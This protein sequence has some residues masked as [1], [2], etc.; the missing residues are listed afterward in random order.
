M[1]SERKEKEGAEC[2][3]F[4]GSLQEIS[5]VYT[6]DTQNIKVLSNLK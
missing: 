5:I 2:A 3:L 1:I 4:P 6:F